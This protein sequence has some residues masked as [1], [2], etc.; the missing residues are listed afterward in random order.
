MSRKSWRSGNEALIRGIVKRLK[1]P[2]SPA[3]QHYTVK[4]LGRAA[5]GLLEYLQIMVKN[6]WPIAPF[7]PHRNH[8]PSSLSECGIEDTDFLEILLEPLGAL[9]LR[10]PVPCV[11]CM[12]F[13]LFHADPT[14]AQL[15]VGSRHS[16]AR[17]SLHCHVVLGSRQGTVAWCLH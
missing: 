3:K 14:L 2:V 17:A 5:A 7:C 6:P 15:L 4:P 13:R 10:L 11:V 8:H 1:A 9:D 16:S 12:W